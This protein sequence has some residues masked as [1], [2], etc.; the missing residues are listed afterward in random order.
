M[1]H[2][3]PSLVMFVSLEP[4]CY[5]PSVGQTSLLLLFSRVIQVSDGFFG[6]QQH[7]CELAKDFLPCLLI[8][9]IPLVSLENL[10]WL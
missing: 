5:L 1:C 3:Y 7:F 8:F 6:Y 2:K 4:K 9:V 10:P